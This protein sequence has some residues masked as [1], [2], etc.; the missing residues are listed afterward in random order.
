MNHSI[1]IEVS[2]WRQGNHLLKRLKRLLRQIET[3]RKVVRNAKKENK[4]KQEKRFKKLHKE[5]LSLINQLLERAQESLGKG[6]FTKV[7]TIIQLEN[8]IEHGLRQID[9]IERRIF[10]GEKIPHDEKVFSIFEPQTE[11]IS[12]GKS[13]VSQELGLKVAIVED[14][15]QFILHRIHSI[16]YCS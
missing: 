15:Y 7:S 3:M 5:Y 16:W 12:K 10:K 2:G 1:E 11:W 8:Y 9:Q 6:S 4:K 13:G 14:Q